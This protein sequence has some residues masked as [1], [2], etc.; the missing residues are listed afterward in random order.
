[1]GFQKGLEFVCDAVWFIWTVLSHTESFP[2][3]SHIKTATEYFIRQKQVLN[4]TKNVLHEVDIY[5]Q[6]I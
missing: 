5:L 3:V 2:V 4:K 1:M 6:S